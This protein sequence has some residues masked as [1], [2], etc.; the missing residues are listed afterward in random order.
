VARRLKIGPKSD[1]EERS[2]EAE[3]L[4]THGAAGVVNGPM[5]R[6]VKYPINKSLART[7]SADKNAA[8]TARRHFCKIAPEN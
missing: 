2:P 1:N 3:R 4:L 6:V 7:R 5:E 8:G